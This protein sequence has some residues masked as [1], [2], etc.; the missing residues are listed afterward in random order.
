MR[1]CAELSWHTAANYFPGLDEQAHIQKAK[2]EGNTF[3]YKCLQL[4][5][6]NHGPRVCWTVAVCARRS[7]I[8]ITLVIEI[9]ISQCWCLDY[10]W[11]WLLS[12]HLGRHAG[13][14][15][16]HPRDESEGQETGKADQNKSLINIWALNAKPSLFRLCLEALWEWQFFFL[17]CAHI[18]E[19]LQANVLAID[20][21]TNRCWQCISKAMV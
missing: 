3:Q 15:Q 19:K 5:Y 1:G 14:F 17:I 12:K 8:Y 18:V 7:I 20:H 2:R 13:L 6:C 16:P 21:S 9:Y 10:H 11:S 4:L